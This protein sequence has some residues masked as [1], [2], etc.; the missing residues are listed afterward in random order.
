MRGKQKGNVKYNVYIYIY[1]WNEME[2]FIKSMLGHL[3]KLLKQYKSI[4]QKILPSDITNKI[5]FDVSYGHI[6]PFLPNSF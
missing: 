2:Q 5:Y 3:T 6:R 1:K 4:T